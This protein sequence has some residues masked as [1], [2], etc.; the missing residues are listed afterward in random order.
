MTWQKKARFA[1]VAFVLVFAAVV[2][3]AM[4]RRAM[5]PAAP[6]ESPRTDPNTVSETLG[7]V[8][9]DHFVAGKL[10]YSIAG[11]DHK[12]FEDGRQELSAVT[13]TMPDRNGRTIKI[14][15]A[16]A[17]LRTPPGKPREL[18]RAKFVGQVRLT[19][20]DG[21][22]VNAEEG[23]YEG[24]SGMLTVPGP[25]TFGKGRMTGSGVGA[26]YD[27]T[28]DVLW[29]LDQARV[30]VAADQHGAGSAQA[31]AGAA[32]LARAENYVKLSRAAHIVTEGRTVDSDDATILLKEDGETI[33]QMQL[34]GNSRIVGTGAGSQSMSARDIDLSYA[35][36][37][38]TLQSAR[39]MEQGVLELPASAGSGSR[40]IA[41]RTIDFS[42][43]A[44]GT[45]VSTLNAAG[46]VVMD[47][48]GEAGATVKQIRASTLT[49]TG[50]PNQGVQQLVF[51]GPVEFHETRAAGR[52][53]SAVDRTARAARLIVDT[54]AGLGSIDRA[55]FRGNV[56]I[57]D[58]P[59]VTAGAPRAVYHL[60]SQQMELSPS[61]AEPGPAPF[62]NDSQVL[63]EA[64]T[65]RFS[66]DTRRLVGDT[67][68]RSTIRARRRGAKN[69]RGAQPAREARLPSMLAEDEP[70]TVTANRVDYD[71]TAVAKYDGNARLW[72]EKSKIYADT[73]EIDDRSGNLTARGNTKTTMLLD[74]TDPKTKKKTT[75]ETNAT[76]EVMVYEDAK[77][78]ATYTA[79]PSGRAHI[80][81]AHGDL[82]ADR[83]ELYLREGGKELERAVSDGNVVVK[84]GGRTATGGHLVYTAAN[85]TYVMTGKPVEIIEQ[86][87]TGCEKTI[88]AK[89]T[90][91]RSNESVRMEND[92]LQLV[93][94]KS[95]PCPAESRD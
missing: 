5:A 76:A 48:P 86:K 53:T 64:R 68:V 25:V 59:D 47:L 70:V 74:D 2:F 10:D 52:G 95:I 15:A 79:G 36:D 81:G 14:T 7:P 69:G 57:T 21:I 17:D 87:S 61:G 44:D 85:D 56:H 41:A 50:P 89:L 43:T 67:D 90:F 80:V 29:I 18:D 23:T 92:G 11:K 46:S 33:R 13:L 38:R 28:R 12:A 30:D 88:G 39:L 75:A 71:G 27:R 54:K 84:E 91:N 16:R 34:R 78:L 4:R 9:F 94:G 82:T 6:A 77:R 93:D 49:A 58:G 40:R 65:L 62:V 26:T 63:I 32:G 83:T 24:A 72:Q 35:D 45:T 1:I 31:T 55:D 20:S 22:T 66:P 60:A 8:S 51:G 42:L 37:G 19:S 3:L 73:I